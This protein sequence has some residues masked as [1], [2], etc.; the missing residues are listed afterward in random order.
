LTCKPK[1]DGT[2][3]AA[4]VKA[5]A[6]FHMTALMLRLT[7]NLGAK[8]DSD[9]IHISLSKRT[10]CGEIRLDLSGCHKSLE[11]FFISPSAVSMT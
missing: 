6:I 1:M 2:Q 9:R 5:N 3:S 4:R 7:G 11:Y 8:S 10:L